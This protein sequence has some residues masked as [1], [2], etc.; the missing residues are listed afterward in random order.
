MKI[1]ISPAKKMICDA[2]WLAPTRLPPLLSQA[3][4]LVSHLRT[5]S[6]SALQ[7]L[8]CCNDQLAALNYQRYQEM[9][10]RSATTPA[11]LAYQGIQYQYMAPGV[12]SDA[13]LDYLEQNL[14]I[15]SG[16]YGALH[17]FDAVVP[18]RLE[19]QTRLQT[20][21]CHSLYDFWGDLIYKEIV[22]PGE[23]LI[24]LASKEYAKAI[25][26]HLNT[27]ILCIT[28]RFGEWVGK[29]VVEKGVYVKMARGEMVRF[30]AEYAINSPRDLLK[31]D[32][33]GYQYAPALSSP[34]S[35]VFLK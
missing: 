11:L 9:D 32:R 33:L 10:L 29:G 7:R 12:L 25:L 2:D 31:F 19:M 26:P 6:L 21:F 18:Y 3:E 24:N 17:P 35:P 16:L 1:I 27:N 23:I 28:P 30:L 15:L 14:Y 22:M 8:L 13:A 20:P 4:R 34:E 5:L